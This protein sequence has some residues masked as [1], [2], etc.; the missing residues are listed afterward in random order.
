MLAVCLCSFS[1]RK[2]DVRPSPLTACRKPKA[3]QWYLP[4]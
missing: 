3:I 2:Y 4:A 1:S